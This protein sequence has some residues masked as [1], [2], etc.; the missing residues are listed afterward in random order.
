VSI[1]KKDTV[2]SKDLERK[3]ADKLCNILSGDENGCTCCQIV[4]E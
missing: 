4:A 3:M 2:A 1:F